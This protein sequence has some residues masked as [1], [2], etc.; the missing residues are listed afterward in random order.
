MDTFKD[1]QCYEII[2]SLGDIH[3][4]KVLNNTNAPNTYVIEVTGN[5]TRS[6]VL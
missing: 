2:P 4:F 6:S 3:P 1:R 5:D